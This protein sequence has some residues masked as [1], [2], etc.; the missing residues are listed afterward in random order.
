M[1]RINGAVSGVTETAAYIIVYDKYTGE[2]CYSA[3]TDSNGNFQLFLAEGS[4]YYLIIDPADDHLKFDSKVIDLKTGPINVT[5]KISFNLVP[6]NSGSEVL[7]SGIELDSLVGNL[8]PGSIQV[9][10]RL[11]RFIQGNGQLK[12]SLDFSISTDTANPA[13]E[14]IGLL[15]ITRLKDSV[16]SYLRGKNLKNLTDFSIQVI[17]GKDSNRNPVV[18]LKTE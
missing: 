6:V 3:R 10:N 2:K 14:A 4:V 16:E 15:A 13:Q 17:P 8:L 11:S 5:E 12:F 18:T 7:L 1:L 9:L